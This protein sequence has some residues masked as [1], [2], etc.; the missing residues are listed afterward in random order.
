MGS[1]GPWIL[2]QR[3]PHPKY[4]LCPGAPVIPSP[5]K[6]G[7][8]GYGLSP[9]LMSWE[10]QEREPQTLETKN[11]CVWDEGEGLCGAG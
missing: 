9:Q 4:L 1:W 8:P 3:L 5:R 2:R 6:A 7:S 11:Q 10:A